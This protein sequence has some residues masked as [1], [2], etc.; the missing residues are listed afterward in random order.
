MAEQVAEIGH[1]I[2]PIMAPVVRQREGE[3]QLPLTRLWQDIDHAGQATRRKQRFADILDPQA[4]IGYGAEALARHRFQFIHRFTPQH[5]QRHLVGRVI[6]PIPL[7]QGGAHRLLLEVTEGLCGTHPQ[8]AERMPGIDHLAQGVEDAA[9]IGFYPHPVFGLYRI[10][11][12]AHV[13]LVKSGRD[14]KLGEAVQRLGQI[15][16]INIKK[17]VGMLK[18]GVGIARA[19]MLGNELLVFPGMRIF[20]RA[21]EQHVLQEMRQAGAFTRIL[22]AAYM[23]IQ[24]R[25]RFFSGGIGNQQRA[26]AVIQGDQAVAP[27]IIWTLYRLHFRRGRRRLLQTGRQQQGGGAQDRATV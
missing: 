21:E 17:V 5:N 2:A 19:A 26:Q 3:L 20:I 8:N 27:V 1:G 13:V 12:P 10:D 22:G 15:F 18:G 23:N 6:T 7:Q 14:K 4:V 16:L 24:G 9:L 25:G 11:F